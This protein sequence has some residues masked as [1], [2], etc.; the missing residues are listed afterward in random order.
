[1]EN[2]YQE[3]GRAGRDGNTS[4]CIVM[5]RLADVFKL[6]TMVSSFQTSG[7]FWILHKQYSSFNNILW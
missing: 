2:F 7:S 3:S 6:S 4:H 5:Y 1:M